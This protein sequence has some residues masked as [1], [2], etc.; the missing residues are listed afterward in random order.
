M[1]AMPLS[2]MI[3]VDRVEMVEFIHRQ[4]WM[5]LALGL[6]HMGMQQLG[7]GALAN[8]EIG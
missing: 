8:F 2:G 5:R 1:C 6:A 3:R 7:I 4:L